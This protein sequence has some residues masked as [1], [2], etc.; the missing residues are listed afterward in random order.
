MQAVTPCAVHVVVARIGRQEMRGLPCVG[1][2]GF[3]AEAEHVALVHQKAHA[4][5]I[6]TGRM[7][8]GVIEILIG[9]RVAAFRPIGPHQHP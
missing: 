8:S 6:G 2:D 3:G 7:L 1:A 9:D 5:W 4:V